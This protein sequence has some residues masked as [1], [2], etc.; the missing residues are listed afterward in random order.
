MLE[1]RRMGM[2]YTAFDQFTK[3][4]KLILNEDFKYSFEQ[5]ISEK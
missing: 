1:M 2:A 4:Y 3:E 5:F